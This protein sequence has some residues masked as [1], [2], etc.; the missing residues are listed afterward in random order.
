MSESETIVR[1]LLLAATL[2]GDNQIERVEVHHIDLAPSQ[3]AGLHSHPC[4]VI[5]AVLKGEILL[6][7]E[8]HKEMLL[9]PGNGFYEPAGTPIARFDNTSGLETASFIA[10]YL[11]PPGESRLITMLGHLDLRS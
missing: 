5:G 10:C 8:G 1:R 7:V 6:Q 11:L 4:P 9:G 3:Q 2:G